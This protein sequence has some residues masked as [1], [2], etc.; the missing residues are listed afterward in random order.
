MSDFPGAAHH[1]S[2]HADV[3]VVGSGFAGAI[4]A[5]AARSQGC[6]V[7]LVRRAY[8]A[9]AL[10]SGAA[11]LAS[12]PVASPANPRGDHRSIRA[13]VQALA[14]RR[15]DHP[16]ASLQGRLRELD[17]AL[18]FATR[19]TDGA[20]AFAP[21]DDENRLLLSP[22]GTLKAT[23]GGLSTTLAG[24]MTGIEGTVGVAGFDLWPAHDATTVARGGDEA[25]A[26]AGLPLRIEPV[27]LDLLR[28]TEDPAL[29]PHEVAMRIGALDGVE[30]LAASIRRALA[31]RR[32]D[33][34]LLPPILSAGDTRPMV[35][36]L[37][38]LLGVPC[39]EMLAAPPSLPGM[40]LQRLLDDRLAAAGIVIRH[41]EAVAVGGA[42]FLRDPAPEVPPADRFDASMKTGTE[43]ERPLA[44]V[45]AAAVV[46]ATGKF[47]GGGLVRRYAIAE[48]VFGLPVWL[49]QALESTRW[50][51]DLTA[52]E[53]AAEQPYFRAG[54]RIDGR[55]RPLG[56]DGGPARPDLFACGALLAGNDAARDGAGLGLAIFTGYLAGRE[57]A[58]AA[59]SSR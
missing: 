58:A 10:S 34:L 48:T 57:A 53:L 28:G 42:L 29:R 51:G 43:S 39:A 27:L 47:L 23:A 50:P 46:L 12:D 18:E 54:L 52:N 17:E 3:V 35:Q 56:A 55:L 44:P 25:A 22:L 36:V 19:A 6:S 2:L 33:R 41:A 4:A 21:L 37:G 11:D 5:L 45:R 8:G 32:I 7:A 13:S 38:S 59:Q 14:L 16:Y 15:P 24:A 30:R 20:L 9:T 31:G 40:R 49:G 26:R 1:E